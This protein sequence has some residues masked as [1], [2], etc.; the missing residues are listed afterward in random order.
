M[1]IWL[2]IF[3][4][5]GFRPIFQFILFLIGVNSHDWLGHHELCYNKKTWP[6]LWDTWPNFRIFVKISKA[7]PTVWKAWSTSLKC[8]V[9]YF[10]TNTRSNLLRISQNLVCKMYHIHWNRICIISFIHILLLKL[11]LELLGKFH[12]SCIP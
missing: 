11:F 1:C 3:R 9:A 4:E 5:M 12:I 6:S 2:S 7:R 8:S 10:E